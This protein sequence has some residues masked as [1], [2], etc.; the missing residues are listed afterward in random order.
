MNDWR[1]NHKWCME[2]GKKR[3]Y[4]WNYLPNLGPVYK[5]G[6]CENYYLNITPK[7]KRC[8]LRTLDPDDF[9]RHYA[10]EVTRREYTRKLVKDEVL[11]R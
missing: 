3:I 8:T 2:C 1:K 6:N 10:N 4:F 11:R 5:C 7:K 9:I